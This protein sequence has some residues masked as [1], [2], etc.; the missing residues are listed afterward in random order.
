MF[1][2]YGPRAPDDALGKTGGE[3]VRLLNVVGMPGAFTATRSVGDT[4]IVQQN[5]DE[6]GVLDGDDVLFHHRSSVDRKSP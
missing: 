6:L 1:R 2:I 3:L 5:L 4:P